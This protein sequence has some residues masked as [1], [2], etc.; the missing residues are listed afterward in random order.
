MSIP[1]QKNREIPGPASGLH[2][3]VAFSLAPAFAATVAP[4]QEKKKGV[5][6]V[7]THCNAQTDCNPCRGDAVA[8]F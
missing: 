4:A 7:L 5:G 6:G 1:I 3:L 2:H 8:V